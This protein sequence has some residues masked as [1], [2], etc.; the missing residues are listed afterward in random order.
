MEKVQMKI[1]KIKHIA[2]WV[3]VA[4]MVIMATGCVTP[5]PV[6]KA[7]QAPAPEA[8]PQ[9]APEDGSEN[10]SED[11]PE[12]TKETLP[13]RL[14]DGRDGFNIME[15]AKMSGSD[16]RAFDEAVALLNTQAYDQ[17]IEIL[18]KVVA[19]SPGVTAP[20]INLGMAYARTDRIDDAEAQFKKALALVPGHPVAG[21]ECGLLFRKKGRFEEARTM[22]EQ[23]LDAYPNYYPVHRNLGILCDLYLNDLESALNHY[24]I[25]SQAMPKEAQVKLWIADLQGRIGTK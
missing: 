24:Q 12:D 9:Y 11:A 15:T 19:H 23:V 4:A 5:K 22:Y 13:G 10:G 16:R 17:A 21:N 7:P 20:Y 8:A 14:P 25:Y 18:K 6:Q 1:L 2:G 3:A